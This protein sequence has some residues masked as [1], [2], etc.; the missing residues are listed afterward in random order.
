MPTDFSKE[1]ASPPDTSSSSSSSKN[2]KKDNNISKK[3]IGNQF[4]F[5]QQSSSKKVEPKDHHD[6]I[7]A[8]SEL[9]QDLIIEQ[10]IDK[11]S[12]DG[13]TRFGFGCLLTLFRT[14][15]KIS[16]EFCFSAD[17]YKEDY[18]DCIQRALK[19][20]KECRK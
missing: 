18:L 1:I 12:S 13:T 19:Y 10:D 9:Y 20:V 5:A 8:H 11:L 7:F 6:E 17:S 15:S 3:Y 2:Q 4:K 14:N 16:E